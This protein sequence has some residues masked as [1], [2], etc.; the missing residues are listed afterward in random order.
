MKTIVLGVG[1]K[2]LSDEGLGVEAVQALRHLYNFSEKVELLDGGTLGL[3]LLYFLDGCDRLLI[4]DAVLGGKEPGTIYRIEGQ[5]VKGYFKRKVSAHEI[6][7]QE[8]LAMMEIMGKT[9]KEVCVM[10]IEPQRFDISTELSPIVKE[11]LPALLEMVV[12]KLKEWGIE[13]SPK[14]AGKEITS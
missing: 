3:D 2:L 12:E 8:V 1:N 9:P 7:I 5:D 11:K 10:G 6:G 13:V 14:D 4:L